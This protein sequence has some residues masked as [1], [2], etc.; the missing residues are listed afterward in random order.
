MI[1]LMY[2]TDIK[3]FIHHAKQQKISSVSGFDISNLTIKERRNL[4]FIINKIRD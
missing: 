1:V 2:V 4:N 3:D